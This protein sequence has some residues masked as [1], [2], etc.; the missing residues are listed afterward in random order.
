MPIKPCNCKNSY[1]D[2]QYGIGNRVFNKS[3]AK[4]CKKMYCTVCSREHGGSEPK[5][6]EVKK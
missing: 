3:S 5:K 1:Q 2:S 4:D 6:T